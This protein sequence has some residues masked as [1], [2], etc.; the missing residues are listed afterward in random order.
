ML[1]RNKRIDA[2]KLAAHMRAEADEMEAEAEGP[3]Q[4]K[5]EAEADAVARFE[6]EQQAERR[7]FETPNYH[8]DPTAASP[9]S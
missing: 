7:K 4:D 9:S 2:D 1:Q 8:A 3:V 6:E 5:I